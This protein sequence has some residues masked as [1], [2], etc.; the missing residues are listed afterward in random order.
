MQNCRQFG[1]VNCRCFV[2]FHTYNG[3]VRRKKNSFFRGSLP[4]RLVVRHC[5]NSP[6][7]AGLCGIFSFMPDIL[8]FYF[9]F[10]EIAGCTFIFETEARSQEPEVGIMTPPARRD[11]QPR[12]P[13]PT[14]CPTFSPPVR[15]FLKTSGPCSRAARLRAAA[16][17][18]RL[19]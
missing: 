13:Q 7:R 10:I 18:P 17:S 12:A 3:F 16:R 19:H 14:L 2:C 15:T 4:A 8:S 6:L 5:G 11:F 1:S 9:V